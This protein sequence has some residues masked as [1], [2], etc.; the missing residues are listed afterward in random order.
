MNGARIILSLALL[1]LPALFLPWIGR[2][3]RPEAWA[4]VSVVSLGAGFVLFLAAMFHAVLPLA[5]A[6]LGQ[7]ELAAACRKLGGHLFGAAAPFSAFAGL[8]AVVIMV[9][10]TRGVRRLVQANQS[11]QLGEELGV[12]GRVGGV[13]VVSIPTPEPVALAVPGGNPLV[14]MSRGVLKSLALPQ[15]AAVV[16]HEM[17]HL[18]H[19]HRWFLVMGSLVRSGLWFVPWVRTSERALHLSLER[20]ADEEAAGGRR[21][22]WVHLREAIA[23]LSPSGDH[24]RDLWEARLAAAERSASGAGMPGEWRWWVVAAAVLPLVVTLTATLVF[25]LNEVFQ[26]IPG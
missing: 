17:A 15:A 1:G 11:L 10:S 13:D 22:R 7:A 16:R 18:R 6:A 3:R 20:W 21:E 24:P 14:L 9:Q 19:H 12:R 4:G 25:H 2:T 26:H 8:L 23:R 5:F